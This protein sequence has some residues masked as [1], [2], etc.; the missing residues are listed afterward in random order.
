MSDPTPPR[1][2]S[3]LALPSAALHYH[4]HAEPHPDSEAAVRYERQRFSR[5]LKPIRGERA[6]TPDEAHATPSSASLRSRNPP[7]RSSTRDS[8]DSLRRRT[9]NA[10]AASTHVDVYENRDSGEEMDRTGRWYYPV[11]KFWTK[12][13]SLTIEEGAHRDHLGASPFHIYL[14]RQSSC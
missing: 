13:I 9:S 12:H 8:R 7:Q 1:V 3:P 14:I 4:S 2:L 10:D 6:A 5:E 11:V